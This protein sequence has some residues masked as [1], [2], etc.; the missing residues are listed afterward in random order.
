MSVITKIRKWLLG[1]CSKCERKSYCDVF[2]VRYCERCL[3][4][5]YH[6]AMKREADKLGID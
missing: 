4:D 5:E 1:L 2:G 6:R 3:S